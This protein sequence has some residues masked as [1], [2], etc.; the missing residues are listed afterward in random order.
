MPVQGSAGQV[1]AMFVYI[2]GGGQH[3]TNS[4][5]QFVFVQ[6]CIGSGKERCIQ[7]AEIVGKAWATMQVRTEHLAE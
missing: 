6:H 3:I 5:S 1:G 7:V 4:V 2:S